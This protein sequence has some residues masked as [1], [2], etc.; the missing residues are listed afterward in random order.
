MQNKRRNFRGSYA[1]NIH[2]RTLLSK[3]Y[4]KTNIEFYGYFLLDYCVSFWLLINILMYSNFL[5]SFLCNCPL[6]LLFFI[7]MRPLPLTLTAKIYIFYDFYFYFYLKLLFDIIRKYIFFCS[8]YSHLLWCCEQF[9]VLLCTWRRMK[10][11]YFVLIC[12]W[13]LFLWELGIGV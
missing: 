2:S 9:F 7:S 11:I 4:E 8:V 12:I 6:F 1:E 10:G 5:D 3:N 13:F